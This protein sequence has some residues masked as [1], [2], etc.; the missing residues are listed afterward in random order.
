MSSAERDGH[1]ERTMGSP[2]S[3]QARI[4]MDLIDAAAALWVNTVGDEGYQP[5]STP[6]SSMRFTWMAEYA[7]S[8]AHADRFPDAWGRSSSRRAARRP[9]PPDLQSI[10]YQREEGVCRDCGT[11][12]DTTID[13]I[14]PVHLGGRT[15]IHNLTIRCRPCNSRKGAR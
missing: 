4:I 11:T 15:E 12:E 6:M 7:W 13:H 9:T 8:H 1:W 2:P 10:V 3:G 14:V 5:G